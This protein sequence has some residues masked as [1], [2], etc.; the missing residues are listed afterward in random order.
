LDQDILY[1]NICNL[2]LSVAHSFAYI[3]SYCTFQDTVQLTD[4][5]IINLKRLRIF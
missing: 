1:V 4:D 5:R 2:L 3:Y